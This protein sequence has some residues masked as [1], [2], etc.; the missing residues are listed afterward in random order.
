MISN[1]SRLGSI[2]PVVIVVV[3]AQILSARPS[4]AGD[5][6][7]IKNVADMVK[8]ISALRQMENS[9]NYLALAQT[10]A[11]V[12]VETGVPTYRMNDSDSGFFGPLG[13][14]RKNTD[15]TETY[16]NNIDKRIRRLSV[17]DKV[18]QNYNALDKSADIVVAA[19]Y[20]ALNQLEAGDVMGATKIYAS[21][22][23]PELNDARGE[24]YTA[25]SNLERAIAKAGILCK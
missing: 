2:W 1:L 6:C 13:G 22:T 15:K 3:V 9:L 7:D 5:D 21:V 14:L 18:E 12:E 23:V 24:A 11:I 10:N 25:M 20:D 16:M 17:F 8:A 19:G 4:V